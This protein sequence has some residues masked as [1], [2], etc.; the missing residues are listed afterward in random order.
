MLVI[1]LGNLKEVVVFKYLVEFFLIIGRNFCI[2]LEFILLLLD[3]F[4]MK[5][6]GLKV[7][8]VREVLYNVKCM[9]YDEMVGFLY[10]IVLCIIVNFRE[11]YVVFRF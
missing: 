11:K 5:I 7:F 6:I 8:E 9:Y 10:V 3:L 1:N 2:V 4:N